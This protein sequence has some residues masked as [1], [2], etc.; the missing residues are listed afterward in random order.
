[1]AKKVSV[2]MKFLGIDF[3]HISHKERLISALG[4]FLGIGGIL[5][6]TTY[7][8]DAGH[9]A[10]LVASMGAS[11]VLL[12]AVPHGALSQ[13]W[14][15]LG[16]HV[17]SAVIGV[18]I[19]SLVSD[20]VVAASL[21]VGLAVGAMHYLRCIHPP[22]G[23]TAVSAV[24][25]GAEVHELGYQF[26]FTPVLLNVLVI[27]LIAI[28]FNYVFE[29]R[30]YPAY[31]QQ[32]RRKEKKLEE[33]AKTTK[34]GISHE[35]FVYALSEVDSFIDVS[36]DDLLYIYDLATGASDRRQMQ[37]DDI[38]LGHYYSNGK[39]SDEWSVRQVV[40][41]SAK[42]DTLIYKVVAGQGRRSSGVTSKK[43]FARWAM[44][45]VY[46]DEENWRRITPDDE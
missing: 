5:L 43:E 29:W 23:A 7:Y 41:Q 12:F 34:G 22:G 17:I 24:I 46:L 42:E 30:R 3:N 10:L 44:Y 13:P 25:G 33:Q 11:A 31:L 16:G 19:A 36:E 8:V 38:R 15:V 9:A 4:A 27:L 35:D 40:D 18:T 28:I 37:P 1:M 45:E 20:E 2:L 39:F 14:P 32:L 6:V 21:A 26:V